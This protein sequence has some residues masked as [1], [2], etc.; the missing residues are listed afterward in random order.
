MNV[1]VVDVDLA[2]EVDRTDQ[3]M[4]AVR[5]QVCQVEHAEASEGEEQTDG[6]VVLDIAFDD[7][8]L[9]VLGAQRVC[10]ACTLRRPER[11]ADVGTTDCDDLH[12][13]AFERDRFSW[14]NH[15]VIDCLAE[16]GICVEPV[17]SRC[18]RGCARGRRREADLPMVDEMANRNPRRE[19]GHIADVPS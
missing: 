6:L 15:S 17:R 3:F 13:Y 4:A 19:R 5:F 11:L 12:R 7:R 9:R 1:D 18:G 2:D 16:C 10:G 8:L 14:L